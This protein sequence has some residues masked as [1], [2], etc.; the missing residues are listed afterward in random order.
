LVD[1][2]GDQGAGPAAQSVDEASLL[3]DLGHDPV[4]GVGGGGG[5]D[6]GDVVDQ[7]GVG[8]VAD[9]GDH[10]CPARGDGPHQPLVGERQQVLD[11]ATAAGHH[12][13]LD[14]RVGVQAPQAFHHRRRRRRPLHRAVVHLEPDGRPAPS[15]GDQ[16][17]PLGG[18]VAAGDDADDGRREGQ[19][20]LAD[21]V[22]EPFRGQQLPDPF[23]AGEEFAQAQRPDL[24]GAQ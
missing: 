22:E 16:H 6:V 18:A 2:A 5:P 13:D 4:S 12:D 8:L 3:T 15:G 17:V 14:G 10:G 23:D 7:R 24:G 9:G 20:S 21:G 11:G 1:P 19:W